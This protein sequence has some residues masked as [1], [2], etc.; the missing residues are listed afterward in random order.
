ME[1]FRV[2]PTKEIEHARE[3][4]EEVR[5]DFQTSEKRGLKSD[6]Q[7][8]NASRPEYDPSPGAKPVPG[9]FGNPTHEPAKGSANYLYDGPPPERDPMERNNEEPE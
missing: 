4:E 8:K 9:A 2:D 1:K 6:A 5:G 3:E 7:K